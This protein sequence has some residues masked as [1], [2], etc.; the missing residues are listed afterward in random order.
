[1]TWFEIYAYFGTPVIAV[2]FAAGL[3][4]WTGR[5]DSR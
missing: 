4:W 2:L 5:S 1:M 3:Y